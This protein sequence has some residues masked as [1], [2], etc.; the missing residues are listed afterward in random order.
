MTSDVAV[1]EC[2]NTD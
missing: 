1:I 2:I